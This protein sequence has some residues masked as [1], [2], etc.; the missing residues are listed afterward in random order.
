MAF[1][2]AVAFG[3][4]SNSFLSTYF[5]GSAPSDNDAVPEDTPSAKAPLL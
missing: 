2:V 4:I 1:N 3:Q 5:G